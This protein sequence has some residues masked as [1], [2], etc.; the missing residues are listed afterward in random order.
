VLLYMSENGGERSS[1]SLTESLPALNA[2]VIISCYA[3]II[4]LTTQNLEHMAKVGPG[5]V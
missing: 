5:L 2:D 1:L 3:M 4:I